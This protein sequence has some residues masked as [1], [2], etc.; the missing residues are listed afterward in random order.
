MSHSFNNASRT[1]ICAVNGHLAGF[2]AVLPFPHPKVKD[3]WREHRSVIFPDYQGVGIGRNFT[4]FIAEL[5]AKEG[6]IFVSTTSNPAMIMARKNDN[7]WITTHI[8]RKQPNKGVLKKSSNS[9]ITV[10]FR[11]VGNKKD[12]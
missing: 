1:F 8:G 10:S 12:T 11:Y 6:K 7:K 4:N 3:Y 5:F 9:R 2:C